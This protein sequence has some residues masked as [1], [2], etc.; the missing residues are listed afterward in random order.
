MSDRVI[1]FATAVFAIVVVALVCYS[2]LT[3]GKRH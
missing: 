1:M 2:I 3:R